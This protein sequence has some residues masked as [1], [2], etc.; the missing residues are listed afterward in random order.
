MALLLPVVPLLLHTAAA[1]RAAGSSGSVDASATASPA[2]NVLLLLIDDMGY[3][4]LPD[5]GSP[6]ATTPH[7]SRLIASG[8]KFT[9]WISAAPICTPSRAALQTGRY[10]IGTGCMGNVERYHVIPRS[11]RTAWTRPRRPVSQPPCAGRT[12]PQG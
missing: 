6:N 5:F 10:P 8:M 11:T 7:I 2:P 3:S 4:D 1:G 12:T 9:Q